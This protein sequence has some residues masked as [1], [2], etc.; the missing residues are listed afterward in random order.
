[1]EEERTFDWEK[2]KLDGYRKKKNGREFA[3]K[4]REKDG[5]RKQVSWEGQSANSPR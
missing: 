2:N 3:K 1:V 5:L 4:I